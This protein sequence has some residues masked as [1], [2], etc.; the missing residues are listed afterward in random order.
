MNHI[1][2]KCGKVG[3]PIPE[4]RPAVYELAVEAHVPAAGGVNPRDYFITSG[5]A[6][7]KARTLRRDL[8]SLGTSAGDEAAAAADTLI[9]H[10]VAARGDAIFLETE[11]DSDHRLFCIPKNPRK[12]PVEE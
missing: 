5:D 7:S 2:G 3:D 9:G 8:L 10:L 6:V 11:Y 1:D 4:P 12:R